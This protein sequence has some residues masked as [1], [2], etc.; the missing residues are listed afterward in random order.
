VDERI[1]SKREQGSVYMPRGLPEGPR[2]FTARCIILP[3]AVGCGN[4]DPPR[5]VE[6]ELRMGQLVGRK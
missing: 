5:P 4:C 6:K 3:C 1:A 2:G